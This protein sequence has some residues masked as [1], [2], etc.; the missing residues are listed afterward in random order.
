MKKTGFV[1]IL[2]VSS[3]LGIQNHPTD[4]V[5]SRIVS[6][7]LR[8]PIRFVF[9]GDSRRSFNS[10]DPDADSIFSIARQQIDELGPLFVIHGGDFVQDGY[11]HEYAHFVSMIDSSSTNILTVR[12]NHELYA[13][14][15]PLLYDS[16]F[17]ETDY[18]FDYGRYRFIVLADCQQD[19]L[20]GNY[21][22]YIDY[23][24]TEEQLSWLES[25]LAD[26]RT[27]GLIS[28]VFAHVPPYQP[29]HDTTHCLG[30]SNYYPRP[31]YE[32]SH[33]EQFSNL[34]AEY[35]VPIGFFSHQHLYDRHQYRGV[36][37]IISGGGGAPTYGY[38]SPP[39]FG[40]A[41]HHFLLM[42][43][44]ST[45]VIHGKFYRIGE[46][47]PDSTFNFTIYASGIEEARR[48]SNSSKPEFMV[49]K[50][51]ETIKTK[52]EIYSAAGRKIGQD[53]K[54]RISRPGFYFVVNKNRGIQ[55]IMILP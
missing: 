23:L 29:G 44:D 36:W 33:T 53:G 13:D 37:Y 6:T 45:G 4:L 39:P 15:G 1:L 42:E 51:G 27:R 25:V 5:I 17:G 31:N 28:F 9:I 22:H 2:L 7:P 3:L 54:V 12:G 52:G 10:G 32:M 48:G 18:F 49:L 46:S 19:S 26:A 21:G 43:L 55:K 50:A 20:T 30:Y 34:M 40:C 14:E 41:C 16:I 24:V 11:R 8:Y 38:I 35:G 47:G